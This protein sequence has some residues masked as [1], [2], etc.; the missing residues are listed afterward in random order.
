MKNTVKAW[1]RPGRNVSSPWRWREFEDGFVSF[2]VS[3]GDTT[4]RLIYHRRNSNEMAL[5]SALSR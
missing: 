4:T 3:E 1:L 5:R 2:A